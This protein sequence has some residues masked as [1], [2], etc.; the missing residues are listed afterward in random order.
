[1]TSPTLKLVRVVLF[2]DWQDR[3]VWEPCLRKAEKK[4]HADEIGKFPLKDTD[5]VTGVTRRYTGRFQQYKLNDSDTKLFGK[6]DSW[7]FI[8]VGNVKGQNTLC[9]SYVYFCE[10]M[11]RVNNLFQ[12]NAFEELAAEPENVFDN[13]FNCRYNRD[14]KGILRGIPLPFPEGLRHYTGTPEKIAVF[15]HAKACKTTKWYIRW[16]VGN[17]TIR[18]GF[19]FDTTF[20]AIGYLR[21]Q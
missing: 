12:T 10:N 16:E 8:E 11:E 5:K 18:P 4:E 14:E 15:R 1:M 3:D 7:R 17:G 9:D 13:G 6:Y 19:G 21:E 20:S 2:L